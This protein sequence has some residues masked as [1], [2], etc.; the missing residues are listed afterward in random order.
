M[1]THS[2]E[3]TKAIYKRWWFIVL[4]II[5]SIPIIIFE[6]ACIAVAPVIL[7]LEL[8]L[9]L[10]IYVLVKVHKNRKRQKELKLQKERMM[11]QQ[12][13]KKICDNF[14]I[15]NE[16]HK[17][18][19]LDKV[20][21]FSQIIDCELVEDGTS[22]SRTIGN[23]KI[24]SAKKMHTNYTTV[25]TNIC[26]TLFINITTTDINNPRVIFDCRYGKNFTKSSRA[27]KEAINN[28]QNIIATLKIVIAQNNE[29]YIESG[30]ITKIEH[31][32]ITEENASI[33]IERL[34]QLHKD[35]ILTDY[36]FEMK[37]KELLDKIK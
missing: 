18:N 35:G 20:Y 14:F 6:I 31:K 28:A 9:A 32:Y 13:Y 27:Y 21:G 17:L 1:E 24:K 23:S 5:I 36:E 34:S 16:E 29:K 4:M 8:I 22:I 11:A 15:N 30:T 33:Q 25:Q 7:V 2:K 3:T 10:L 12:G 26:T 19:I 37:K